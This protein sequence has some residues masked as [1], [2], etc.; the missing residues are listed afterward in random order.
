MR[1]PWMSTTG[2]PAPTISY[3][4]TAPSTLSRCFSSCETIVVPPLVSEREI[5]LWDANPVRA[6]GLLLTLADQESACAG[7]PTR[8]GNCSSSGAETSPLMVAQQTPRSL[9]CARMIILECGHD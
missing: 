5:V 8:K 3:S 4:N 7:R 9:S 1:A 6:L 2:S